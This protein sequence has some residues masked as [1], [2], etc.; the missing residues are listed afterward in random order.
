[1]LS[2][3]GEGTLKSQLLLLNKDKDQ[4]QKFEDLFGYLLNQSKHKNFSPES[5]YSLFLELIGIDNV[6]EFAHKIESYG[7][8][9]I[10]RAIGD[11]VISYFSNPLELIQYLL[12]ATHTY[13][14]TESDINNLLIRMIMERGMDFE[15][16]R[17]IDEVE[18]K[19]WRSRKFV[20]TFILVNIVLLILILLF[21]LRKR[22]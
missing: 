6:E 20:T 12:A 8:T 5:I 11:T 22:K 4:I 15:S 21:S 16:I 9:S 10:N 7:Y 17:T 2:Q 18:G 19:I 13:D 3:H 1:M 14:F